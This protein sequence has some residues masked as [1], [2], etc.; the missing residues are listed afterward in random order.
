[1]K[2]ELPSE[3]MKKSKFVVDLVRQCSR[4]GELRTAIKEGR[5]FQISTHCFGLCDVC[6]LTYY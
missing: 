3:V 4:V 1:M 2:N 6:T 5:F